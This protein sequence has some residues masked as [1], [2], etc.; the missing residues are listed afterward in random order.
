MLVIHAVTYLQTWLYE[1]QE[2]WFV[3]RKVCES[4]VSHHK[5]NS[6]PAQIAVLRFL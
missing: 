1:R 3:L 2:V 4:A 5:K 6:F